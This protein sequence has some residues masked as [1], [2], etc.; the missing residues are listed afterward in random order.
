M[1][2]SVASGKGGTGKTTIATSLALSLDNAQYVDCDV[3]EPNG[4]LFLRPDIERQQPVSIPVPRVDEAKCTHCGVCAD[5]CEFNALAVFPNV[6][7]VFDNLCHGC[8]ACTELCPEKAIHEVDHEIGVL[9]FGHAGE[10]G[11]AHGILNLGEPMATPVI[12]RLKKEI[13]PDKTIVLDAPPGTSCPVVET[14]RTSDYCILVAEPTPFGLN[15]LQLAVEML[16]EVGVP[17][18]VIIN[19]STLGDNQVENFCQEN[20]IPVLLRI[21]FDR[22]IAEGY[23]RGT[24][25]VRLIPHYREKFRELVQKIEEQLAVK[26]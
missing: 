9:E 3:E 13:P 4:H 7:M 2:L 21:P 5:I 23:S 22:R 18:G 19:K 20:G 15:D 11:F 12:R 14:V 25:L 8:G 17:H 1:I 24:P 6:V 10:L 16:Q 26:R